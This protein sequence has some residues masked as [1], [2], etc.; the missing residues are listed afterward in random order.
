MIEN[1]TATKRHL[2]DYRPVTLTPTVMKC[3]SGLSDDITAN[4]PAPHDP[5]Q[6]AY[7]PNRSTEDAIS[8]TLHSIITHLDQKVTFAR[9]LYIDFSSAFNTVIPQKLMAKLVLLRLN[10]TCL[11]I[12]VCPCW[13]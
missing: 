1:D 12:S 3:F 6:F 4:L 10:T 2:T 7:R 11:W 13:K 9:I 5:H 8:T